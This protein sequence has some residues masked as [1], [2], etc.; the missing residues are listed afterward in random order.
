MLGTNLICTADSFTSSG[1]VSEAPVYQET[2]ESSATFA[3]NYNTQ[4]SLADLAI[5]ADEVVA[6]S[7]TNNAHFGSNFYVK[8]EHTLIIVDNGVFFTAIRQ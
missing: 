6:V 3:A 1:A 7:I 5:S 8:D 2:T 4:L